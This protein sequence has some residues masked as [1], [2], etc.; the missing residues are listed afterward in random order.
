[1][2]SLTLLDSQFFF[3]MLHQII[4]GTPL[5]YSIRFK[6]TLDSKEFQEAVQHLVDANPILQFTPRL[7]ETAS[8]FREFRM[9]KLSNLN[10]PIQWEDLTRES[11]LEQNAKIEDTFHKELNKV[12]NFDSSPLYSF[13]LF[14]LKQAEFHLIMSMAHVLCDGLG[15]LQ[16]LHQFFS[17][18][19]KSTPLPQHTLD[20]YNRVAEQINQYQPSQSSLAMFDT[21]NGRIKKESFE[22]NPNCKKF[23]LDSQDFK[24]LNIQIDRETTQRLI[25]LTRD[26][27]ISFYSII[28]TA[29]LDYFFSSTSADRIIFTLPTSG[30]IYP[31]IDA[32]DLVGCFAQAVSL[33]FER[34]I[35]QQSIYTT[36]QAVHE[37]I[38][39]ALRSEIDLIQ[40]QNIARS[41]KSNFKLT[42]GKLSN[43]SKTLFRSTIKS[44][45]YLSFTGHSPLQRHYGKLEIIN[46]R[47][48][49]FNNGGVSDWMH[50]IFNEELYLFA[51][52]DSRYFLKETI[53]TV[54]NHVKEKLFQMSHSTDLPLEERDCPSSFN[55]EDEQTYDYLIS[56]CIAIGLK[57]VDRSVVHCDLEGQ[58]GLDSLS[59]IR[60][61]SKISRD[62]DDQIPKNSLFLCRTLNEF[63]NII[64]QTQSLR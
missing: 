4:G 7:A 49:T 35:L 28:V 43:F 44:N 36:I 31:E 42:N 14:K 26:L 62:H 38:H 5:V 3:L 51:N 12:T 27:R 47:E 37:Q 22:W 39:S 63:A 45:I 15:S 40:N 52:Y 53:E 59:R 57:E 18:L 30:K 17:Y 32:L 64:K 25:R 10:L 50:T 23:S 13:H 41:I 29:Y 58:L 16:L 34:T 60:L 55:Q 9:E 33:S 8:S 11:P 1:M 56:S 61:I 21:I 54:I 20:E 48:G 6:G 2:T 19:S 46:Y 24:V